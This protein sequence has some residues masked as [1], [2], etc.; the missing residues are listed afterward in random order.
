MPCRCLC[1]SR[2]ACGAALGPS[3]RFLLTPAKLLPTTSK[4]PHLISVG[5]THLLPTLRYFSLREYPFLIPIRL[6]VAVSGALLA[7]DGLPG[8]I[9][10]RSSS[11]LVER[12]RISSTTAS[13]PGDIRSFLLPAHQ[14]ERLPNFAPTGFDIRDASPR[15]T[16]SDRVLPSTD[17]SDSTSTRF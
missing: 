14:R 3:K 9:F 6:L 16:T 4:N 10:S 17:L 2:A 5:R 8:P 11:P 7:C 13:H 1:V 15:T 12:G